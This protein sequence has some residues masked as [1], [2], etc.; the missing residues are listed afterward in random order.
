MASQSRDLFRQKILVYL[1]MSEIV[2]VSL[3]CKRLHEVVEVNGG[4]VRAEQNNQY[5]SNLLSE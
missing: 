1:D 5:L 2:K 3:L 4:K